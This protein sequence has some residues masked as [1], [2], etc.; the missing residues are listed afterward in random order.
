M[1]SY[2]SPVPAGT[3]GHTNGH[4]DASSITTE[5]NGSMPSIRPRKQTTKHHHIWLVTGPAGSGKTTVAEFLADKLHLPYIEGDALHTKANVE[6]MRNG[7][8]LN[9]ADRWDWLTLLR[10]ESTRQIASGSEGVV[11]TCSALKRK[12]R[13]VIRVAAYF[14]PLI[15]VHFI[16]LDASE[17][18][19]LRR[20]ANRKGH[21]MGANM[22]RSQF[23]ILERPG[24]EEGDVISVDVGRSPGE[25]AEDALSRVHKIISSDR[26][27]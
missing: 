19:L 2:D 3:N 14:D 4:R 6:K 26:S 20:V 15:R 27:Y 9:D 7:T 5:H 17:D 22:V 18:E 23:D 10:D 11:V 24:A 16:F 13:D 12:Y 21:Y 1:L 8:P 25:V